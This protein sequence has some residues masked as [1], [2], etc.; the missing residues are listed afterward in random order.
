MNES[1][2]EF[3][4]MCLFFLEEKGDPT[5]YSGWDESRF[6]HLAPRVHDWWRRYCHAKTRLN[7]EIEIFKRG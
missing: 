3:I 2:Q 5:R 7:Q 4:D 1:D 6:A